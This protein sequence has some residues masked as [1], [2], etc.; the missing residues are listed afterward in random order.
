MAAM[1]FWG[2]EVKGKEPSKVKLEEGHLIH[3]SQAALG[4]QKKDGEPVILH[5]KVDGKK[6]VLGILSSENNPQLSFDLVFERDFEISHNWKNGSVHLLGYQ[7]EFHD[8]GDDYVD[9]TDEDEDMPIPQKENG[10]AAAAVTK[11][12]AAKP[13][14]DDKPKP[15]AK[16]E[17]DDDDS[18][19][20]E[21]SDDDESDEDMLDMN[22][23]SDDDEEDGEDDDESSE[24]EE[25]AKA[26][27]SGKK[28]KPEAKT[29]EPKKAKTATP[30]KTDGKKGG[31][32]A[33]PHPAKKGGKTPGGDKSTPKSGSQVSCGPCKKTFNSEVALQSHTKAKHS[34]K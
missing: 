31:H 27:E 5:V 26:A 18:N 22:D 30:Q 1:Q 16:A 23:D 19:D 20:D 33:T 24:E 29:P 4:E 32:T 15:E 13:N 21:D 2:I 8:E 3:L 17:D 28:R 34:G 25:P 14:K 11:A 12:I 6:L 10:E 7:S 9:F